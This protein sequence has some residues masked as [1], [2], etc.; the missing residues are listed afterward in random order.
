MK[1]GPIRVLVIGARGQVAQGLVRAL[2]L[3]GFETS[4]AARPTLDLGKPETLLPAVRSAHPDVVINAAAYTAV[5]RAEDEPIIAMAINGIAP[6]ILAAAANTV[7]A[8]MLHFSTDYVFDGKKTTGYIETDFTSPLS[9]YGK[10]KLAGE[11]AVAAAN[12]RHVILRTSW[13]CSPHGTNFVN[14][15]LGAARRLPV[16][17]VVADQHGAP[18]FVAD[19]APVVTRIIE[20][21]TSDSAGDRHFGIYHLSNKGETSRFEFARAILAGSASRGGPSAKVSPIA[22]KD[23]R[24]KAER[25]AYS[26]LISHKLE[27][28]YQITI[29]HWRDSLENCLDDIFRTGS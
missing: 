13:V 23:Y 12:P 7:G 27:E 4:I 6:G 29:P 20:V 19:I 15:I 18:S 11:V 9:E 28:Q 26:K 2:S 17:H 5:D 8:I 14:G 22:T 16:I 1:S 10:S 3:S 24:T 21:A 25:P